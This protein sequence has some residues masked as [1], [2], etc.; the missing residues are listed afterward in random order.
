MILAEDE[1][2]GTQEHGEKQTLSNSPCSLCSPWFIPRS[3]V[4]L[5]LEML[6]SVESGV[7]I[8]PPFNALFASLPAEIDYFPIALVWKIAEAALNVLDLDPMSEYLL[9]AHQEIGQRIRVL[10]PIDGAAS[11]FSGA[12]TGALHFRLQPLENHGGFID[13]LEEPS[14]LR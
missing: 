9:D 1:P 5:S 11:S 6:A 3:G 7:N 13:S 14:Y 10:Y 4:Y 2:R 8:V 12:L